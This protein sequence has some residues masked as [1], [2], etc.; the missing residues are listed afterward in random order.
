MTH[1][2]PGFNYF[3]NDNSQN[4]NKLYLSLLL[5]SACAF[6]SMAA[7]PRNF[8]AKRSVLAD[9]KWVKVGVEQTGVYEISYET[10]RQMGFADPSK[11]AIYGRGG[12]Q[13][14]TNFVNGA[15]IVAIADDLDPVK[16]WHGNN[17]LY[18][19]AL[20]TDLVSF[21][22]ISSC[23]LL[24]YYERKSKNIYS[25][26]G[27]YFLTD[28]QTPST[29]ATVDASSL[30][31][32]PERTEAVTFVYHEKDLIHNNHNTGQLFYGEKVG[33]A[34]PRVEWP[35]YLPKALEANGWMHLEYYLEKDKPGTFS[36]GLAGGNNKVSFETKDA[37][38]SYIQ[39]QTPNE[40]YVSVMPG[41]QSVFA[42]F[43]SK[44]N[45]SVSHVDFWTLSYR[46]GIP[47][48]E[49]VEPGQTPQTRFAFTE[50]SRST[51][52]KFTVPDAS[53]YVVLDVTSTSDPKRLMPSMEAGNATYKVIGSAS[54]ADLVMFDTSRPQLQISGYD[55]SYSEIANQN[56]H[57][58]SEEG[59]DLLIICIPR[60][61]NLAER[62]A[63][64]HRQKEGLKVVVA[65]SEECYNEFSQGVPDP[66]AY[67]SLARMLYDGRIRLKN[68]I[69]M[70][71]LFA[72]FRGVSIPKDPTE[73][74]IAYQDL[75]I[76]WINGAFNANDFYGMMA[77]YINI[78]S[79][80]REKMNVGV[81]LL[82]FRYENEAE[83]YLSKLE[84]YL[85]N[86]HQAYYLNHILSIGG[87]GDSH[88]HETQA[89]DIVT[90]INNIEGRSTIAT[91][92]GTD[93]Y[94]YESAR[95]K[96]FQTLDQGT[97]FMMYFGHGAANMLGKNRYFFTNTDANNLKNEIL[98]LTFFA[99]CNLS[100]TDRGVAGLGE[101]ITTMVPH[102]SIA[103]LIATRDTWSG[104]NM[105]LFRSIFNCFYRQ[106]DSTSGP[107]RTSTPT[108]GEVVAAA[109][110]SSN[111]QNALAYQLIGDPAIRI[112]LAYH[113]VAIF[114]TLPNAVCGE[115]VNIEG[116]ITNA[117]GELQS[118][119]NG[120]LVVRLMEPIVNIK[121][122]SIV[123]GDPN[124]AP[125]IPYA[126][127]QLTM[128]TCK[129][130]NGKFS[131]TLHIPA[132]AIEFDQKIGRLHFS[133]FDND[134]FIGA[135]SMLPMTY[136]K[137]EGPS[138]EESDKEA[139]AFTK[140]EYDASTNSVTVAVTDNYA[141][142][143]SDNPFSKSY[144]VYLDGLDQGVADNPVPL[145]S[146]NGKSWQRTFLLSGL[147]YGN[148]AMRVRVKDAAGNEAEQEI[149]FT[150]A[151]AT[152]DFEIEVASA[153]TDAEVLFRFPALAPEKAAIYILDAHG[154][155]VYSS[156]F[157]GAEFSWNRILNSGAPAASGHYKAYIIEKSANARKGH[158]A[159]IDLPII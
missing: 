106:T 71:P 95:K 64:I 122:A 27:Y 9:G 58:H 77:D 57:Q 40:G 114:E 31:N 94:G 156:E 34:N 73:G 37:A 55:T 138:T 35:V 75:N 101:T 135:G 118:D 61:K 14:N 89:R 39:Y 42:N 44:S 148:H 83:V 49:D 63:E 146:D 92:V 136:A 36:F 119:F 3:D 6:S 102:G 158:S 20:G 142:G 72:D 120:A 33:G 76:S 74:L 10:L 29:M 87:E 46:S 105:E 17:K 108:L 129:V 93:A 1:P 127:T 104:Q 134:K 18:F 67:R 131:A 56:L 19:Y 28:T 155:E 121:S 150:Y 47:T 91:I 115:D 24:G 154:N 79:I 88:A 85:N 78:N 69:L 99:G 151:P 48:P 13:M 116:T 43:D 153:P 66:M 53:T 141:L 139:P 45:P 113:K 126:D 109:K 60:L 25:D 41:K 12:Q 123:T 128:T 32:I 107:V 30:G 144:C 147:T 15:G 130:E 103:S 125:N 50:M 54:Y 132:T 4:M 38:S 21:Q 59:A 149:V 96:I 159:T 26:R 80:E 112:P 62:L 65:T 8:Y 90:W 97:T 152:P 2:P 140:F 5:A 84:T 81:G 133:A 137:N 100:N 7:L 117:D 52:V 143:Y 157:S 11:V 98:P 82:P 124:E 70:G 16:V 145:I 68:L 111:Y 23:E 110:S 22:S 86:E 51:N